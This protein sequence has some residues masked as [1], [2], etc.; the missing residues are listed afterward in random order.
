MWPGAGWVQSP[1]ACTTGPYRRA[2]ID[3][4]PKKWPTGASEEAG[5]KPLSRVQRKTVSFQL[6]FFIVRFRL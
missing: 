3:Y 4:H 2:R 1:E 6:T 5:G